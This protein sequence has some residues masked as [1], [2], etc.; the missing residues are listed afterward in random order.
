MFNSDS[1]TDWANEYLVYITLVAFNLITIQSTIEFSA[2]SFYRVA[3]LT[4]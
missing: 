3:Q 2:T 1:R 4:Q